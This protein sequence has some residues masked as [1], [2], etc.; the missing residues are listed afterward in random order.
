M[1]LT[2]RELDYSQGF[3]NENDIFKRER[4]A[5]QLEN[6]IINSTD[7]SLVFAIDDDWGSGKTTFLRLWENSLNKKNSSKVKAIYF[8]AFENDFQ[9]DAF[10]AIASKIYNLIEKTKPELKERFIEGAKAVGKGLLGVTTKV[11]V[12]FLTAGLVSGT[13]LESASDTISSEVSDPIEKFIEEKLKNSDKDAASLTH[14]KET[15]QKVAEDKKVIFI[16]DELDRARPDFSL[17]ILEKIKHVFSTKNFVFILSMNRVQ[18]EKII[19]KRYGDIDARLYLT[20]FIHHWFTLPKENQNTRNKSAT[21]K[22]CIHLSTERFGNNREFQMACHILTYLL[23]KNKASLRDVERAFGF[24]SLISSSQ[25]NRKSDIEQ[26]AVAI[27]T[28]IITFHQ[29]IVMDIKSK[30]ITPDILF[31]KLNV[32]IPKLSEEEN[33]IATII[34]TEL[35]SDEDYRKKMSDG[36]NSVL[37][38]FGRRPLLLSGILEHIDNMFIDMR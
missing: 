33:Y 4:F 14:F 29:D 5:I 26:V 3:T 24:M 16:I 15:L 13:I 22:Y 6:I 9:Q 28:F 25:L 23:S 35:L 8:D 37:T 21:E 31:E 27:I 20:K 10:L 38:S 32:S 7:E 19:I 2:S 36:S 1:R 12:N 17:E 34:N 11:G 30:K 18:F